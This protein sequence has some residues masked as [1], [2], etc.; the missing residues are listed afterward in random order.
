MFEAIEL[1]DVFL[2]RA[3]LLRF[4]GVVSPDWLII[5]GITLLGICRSF[6][7]FDFEFFRL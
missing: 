4:S 3:E 5:G 6:F 7:S 2:L 1:R